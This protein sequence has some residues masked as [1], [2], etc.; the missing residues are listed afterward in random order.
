METVKIE[1]KQLPDSRLMELYIN[2]RYSKHLS[3]YDA[4][5][6]LDREQYACFEVGQL[7][8]FVQLSKLN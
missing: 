7:V 5:K 2:G 4:I 1:F 8:F 6:I 3:I